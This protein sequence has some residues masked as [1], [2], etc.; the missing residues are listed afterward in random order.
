MGKK[1]ENKSN[2][3][4][5]SVL[6]FF[7]NSPAV[8]VKCNNLFKKIRLA[9]SERA[10]FRHTLAELMDEKILLKQGKFYHLNK[11]A[12]SYQG[13]IILDSNGRYLAE[14]TTEQG[15]QLLNVRTRNL[16]TALPGDVAEVSIIEYSPDNL[17]EAAVEN[18][19]HRAKHR[20]IG[21]LEITD[22]GKYAYVIPDDKYFK[23]DIF[24]PR[25]KLK[26][27][28]RGDKV[29]CEIVKW[30]YQDNAPEGF[31]IEK[32]GKGGEI[33]TEF[34]SLIHKYGLKKSF[35]KNVRDEVSLNTKIGKYIITEEIIKDRIDLRD[36]AI[37]T[38]DPA[39][40]KDFDDAVSIERTDDGCFILGVHIADVSH[41]IEENSELDKEALNRGTSVY[42]MNDV[43]PMLPVKLSNDICSLKPNEDRLTFSVKMEI[44]KKGRIT[45]YKIFKSVI[46]SKHRFAY[47][48]AQGIL[49]RQKGIFL[50]ELNMMNELHNILYKKRIEYGSLDFVSPEVYVEIDKDGRI[51]DIKPK[52]HLETMRIIEDFMLMANKCVTDY[53]ENLKPKP[54][55]IYRVHDK[56]D[57]KKLKELSYFV[58]QFGITLNPESK[59]SIQKMLEY[60]RGKK[61]EF[62][63]NDITIR[64]MAKAIYSDENIG[65]Y[66]LGFNNYTHFTS[67][68]RRYPD[69]QVHRMLHEYIST[70]SKKTDSAKNIRLM[71]ICKHSTAMEINAVQAEREAIRIL[72]IHYLSQHTGKVFSGIIS[73][74]TEYGLYV[75]LTENLIEGMIRLKDLLDDYYILDEKNF[76]L[77]GRH[78]KKHFRIGDRVNVKVIKIDKEKK[79]I[80]FGLV[81]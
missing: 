43:V 25:D 46:R 7:Q 60:I 17:R 18:I 66:G 9:K 51:S 70:K 50:S 65:H 78:R 71:N 64:T 39:D 48:E 59:R 1:K 6:N 41:Y 80:D 36:K 26:G 35:P 32:F 62:L 55:F 14:V 47:E 81:N 57:K 24:I 38:I 16:Y 77:V 20:F 74:V 4:R 67:P 75:E 58:K 5:D 2:Q 31:I 56:P 3:L 44:D 79:W 61:E 10:S 27:S 29:L 21:K 22:K 23:K 54:L 72:Q 8:S 73:G 37:F 11:K 52:V 12:M 53:I 13:K 40:A 15:I 49:D 45:D 33:E 68:I 19:I 34:K 76:Q 63:I 28:V 69:L 42:L 30:D